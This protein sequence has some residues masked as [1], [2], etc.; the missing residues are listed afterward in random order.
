[1]HRPIP[2]TPRLIAL[3]CAATLAAA[4]AQAAPVD[5]D[6]PAQPLP[7]AIKALAWATGASIAA[8]SALLAGKTAPALRGRLEPGDALTRLL[9]GSGLEAVAQPQG[10]WMLRPAAARTSTLGEVRVT[11]QAER[12]ATSEGSGTYVPGPSKGST[13][14]A[15]T[16]RETPQSVSV[17]NQQRI[18]DQALVDLNEILRNMPGVSVKAQDRGRS[19]YFS[20]GFAFYNFQ[21]DGIPTTSIAGASDGVDGTNTAIYDRVETVR[22]ANGLTAGQGLPGASI[23]LVRKHADSKTFT[24][25]VLLEG[26]SWNRY[27]GTVDLSTPLN[28]DGSVRGR[29]VVSQRDQDSFMDFEKR[30]ASVYYLALDAD[31]NSATRFSLALGDQR[32]DR[33][34]IYRGGLPIWYADGT[35]TDWSRSKTFASKWHRWDDRLQDVFASLEHDL[36]NGWNLRADAQHSRSEATL[37]M[38]TGRGYPDRETGLGMSP[39][40]PYFWVARAQQ[41]RF[42][43]QANGPLDLLGRTHDLTVGAMTARGRSH[44]DDFET[45]G[46]PVE[47]GDFNNWQGVPQLQYA[48]ESVLAQADRE[49]QS[50]AYGALRLNLADPLKVIIGARVSR[51]QFDWEDGLWSVASTLRESSVVTPYLGVL[52][53]LNDWMTAY[54]SYTSIFKPQSNRDRTGKQLDPVEGKS[55]ELGIK[56]ELLDGALTAS[57]A[58]FQLQ[59]DNF[60]VLDGGALVPGTEDPAYRAEKGVK[61]KGYELEVTGKL[62]PNWDIG[63]SY[64]YASAKSQDGARVNT[65]V[66]TRMFQMFTKYQLTGALNG[67]SIGG[68]LDWKNDMPFFLA[69]PVSGVM[70][71]IGQSGHVL[72]SLMARYQINK[73]LS[74]QANIYNLFDKKYYESSWNGGITYGEPRRV[75][76]TMDYRF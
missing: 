14:L 54:A 58:V 17:I 8:D 75:L 9:A 55:Y 23:N 30:R 51:Y 31:L 6:L 28:S 61:A 21:I 45:L 48:N 3:A 62:N 24:G 46:G 7:E 40:L 15:L 69:N 11:A 32:N 4:L 70:E 2:A 19:E 52:Y 1:M 50:A 60:A 76:L 56:G 26:G 63:L 29:A 71:D 72:V 42:N 59:Q 74:V 57:A 44:Y 43:V 68:G 5:I 13:G 27:G 22:G 53:D 35:R 64:T 47:M 10:G 67:L 20:R 41:S 34:G 16:L 65:R 37:N 36:D 18:E 73:A 38:M 25:R 33:D 66:P 49:I 39:R 12:S